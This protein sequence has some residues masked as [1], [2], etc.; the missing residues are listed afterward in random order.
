MGK[1]VLGVWWMV[2][3]YE[4][5][6]VI[7]KLVFAEEEVITIKFVRIKL[8][9]ELTAHHKKFAMLPNA[10]TDVLFQTA[11]CILEYNNEKWKLQEIKKCKKIKVL[12]N[13]RS[14]KETVR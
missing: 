14:Q 11:D 3:F 12:S 2:I 13:S 10:D 7:I 9:E 4:I 6:A 1:D 5:V 8:K